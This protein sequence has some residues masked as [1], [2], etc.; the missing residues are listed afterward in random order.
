MLKTSMGPG[1]SRTRLFQ[2]PAIQSVALFSNL[3]LYG[4][5]QAV[6]N[7][8]PETMMMTMA[9][10]RSKREAVKAMP[11]RMPPAHVSLLQLRFAGSG[12]FR[13]NKGH[14][15]HWT[16]TAALQSDRLSCAPFTFWAAMEYIQG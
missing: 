8:P 12:T 5:A 6:K 3:D 7:V 2:K 10:R 14:R 13:E 15:W 1:T 9:L 11:K 16:G 4:Q